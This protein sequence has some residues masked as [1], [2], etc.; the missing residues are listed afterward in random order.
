MRFIAKGATDIGR[1]REANEDAFLIDEERRLYLV[2]DGMGGHQ[3]GGFA[4][5]KALELVL[6]ELRGLENSQEATQ[7]LPQAEERTLTQIRL[8]RA[9][10]RANQKLF[11]ISLSQPQ[12]RGMGTT[13][14][15]LQ[16]DERYANIAHIGDSRAYLIREGKIQQ[17]TEDHSWVQEQ[18]KLGFLTEE[19]AQNHPLKN[20]I[21]RSMGHERDIEVDLGKVEYQPA[22]KYLLCSDGLTNMLSD[23]EILEIIQ[24][25]PLEKAIEQLI[26]R[27]NEEGGYDNI[28]VILVEVAS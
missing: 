12:L 21:T 4:S 8:M 27:A 15:G 13:L 18:V 6:E 16:F 26:L 25:H 9:F 1:L 20:I 5:K 23:Q 14:T 19:E 10:Q 2:A 22:D 24:S 17:L 3:G 11:E 7:P 28:T